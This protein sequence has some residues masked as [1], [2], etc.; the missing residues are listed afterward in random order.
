MDNRIEK[1]RT[2]ERNYHEACYE[3][4]KLFEAGSWLHKPVKTVME[5]LAAFDDR[6]Y[7]SVLDLG[8]GVGRNSI[9]IF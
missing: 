4:Y 1:I 8:S 7:L 3:N 2:E 5:Y 6:E 9:P